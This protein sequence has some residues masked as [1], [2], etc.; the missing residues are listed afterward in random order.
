MFLLN[1]K[2]DWQMHK[3]LFISFFII[4]FLIFLVLAVFYFIIRFGDFPLKTSLIL[5]NIWQVLAALSSLLGMA[6]PI[7]LMYL[8]L[9]NDLGKNKIQYSIY[10]PQPLLAWYLPKVLFIFII[11]GVFSLLDFGYT[12]FAVD[13]ANNVLNIETDFKMIDNVAD[14][15]TSAFS[16]G[17]FALMTVIMALYYSFRNKKIS[18]FL[19]V[20]SVLIYFFGSI[21]FNVYQAIQAYRDVKIDTMTIIL[22]PFAIKSAIGLIYIFIS[23]HLFENKIEY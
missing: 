15:L 10:T 3:S 23:L 12:Y 22:V 7:A 14:T 8:V 18:W 17:F 19:I 6:L 11:Q 5:S 20:T 2:K 13:V 16:F 1:F 21:S 4:S 9:K